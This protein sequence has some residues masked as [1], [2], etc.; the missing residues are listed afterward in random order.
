MTLDEIEQAAAEYQTLHE[1]GEISKEEFVDLMSG[2]EFAAVIAERAED[3]ER[4]AQ[5]QKAVN[6]AIDAASVL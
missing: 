6:I 4:K 3:L 2:L 5:I 1:N